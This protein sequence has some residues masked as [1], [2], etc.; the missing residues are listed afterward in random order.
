MGQEH[1][2]WGRR[3]GQAL[4]GLIPVAALVL[5]GGLCGWL[6]E[7]AG[8]PYSVGAVIGAVVGFMVSRAALRRLFNREQV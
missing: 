1:R 4:A 3:Q 8:G 5:F 6:V 2:S 7:T